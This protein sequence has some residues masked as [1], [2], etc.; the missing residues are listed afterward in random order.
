MLRIRE[1][2]VRGKHNER[3]DVLVR[4]GLLTVHP[5]HTPLCAD[6]SAHTK[7]GDRERDAI[8]P[9]QWVLGSLLHNPCPWAKGGKKSNWKLT[10]GHSNTQAHSVQHGGW[11]P[12][13]LGLSP[14]LV[15]LSSENVNPSF[16]F[17][18]SFFCFSAQVT[19]DSY[20]KKK[21]KLHPPTLLHK[22]ILQHK[23]FKCLVD[24]VWSME[25]LSDLNFSRA[26]SDH[27]WHTQKRTEKTATLTQWK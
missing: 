17:S 25:A 14:S 2:V 4:E 1:S 24:G 27:W 16:S 8:W 9:F 18:L 20:G 7:H 11:W 10:T 15:A 21:E 13:Y 3:D 12:L 22:H 5:L 6:R 19:Q 23:S 26:R